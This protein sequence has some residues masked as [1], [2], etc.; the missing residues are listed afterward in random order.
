M[1]AID[2]KHCQISTV[3]SRIDGS[4]KFGVITSE[5]SLE[6]RATLLAMHGKNVRVMLEPLDVCVTGMDEVTSEA[7]PK[8]PSARLRAVIYIAFEQA[9][10]PGTF[11]EFYRSKMEK[12]IEHIKGKLE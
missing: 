12:I 10:K 8:K 6:H 4:I 11:D 7:E 3:T 1:K 5:L 2:F 9:G